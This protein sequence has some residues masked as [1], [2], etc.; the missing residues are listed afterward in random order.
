MKKWWFGEK[1]HID[2]DRLLQKKKAK[3]DLRALLEMRDET[4]YIAYLKLLNPDVSPEELVR[5]IELF[6]QECRKSQLGASN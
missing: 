5:L 2:Q 3:E 1:K 6:R 4:G